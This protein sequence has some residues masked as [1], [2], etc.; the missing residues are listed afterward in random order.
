LW[1]GSI[2]NGFR[3]PALQQRFYSLITTQSRPSGEL[4]RTGTFRNDSEV[5]K[6]FGISP[7]RAEKTINFSTGVTS[8]IS[9]NISVTIDAYWIQIKNRIIY[10]GTILDTFP[11]VRNILNNSNFKD[12]QNARFFSNA[13][14]TRTIGIDIVFSGSWIIDRSTL[15]V[16]LAANINKTSLYGFIQYAKNLPDN[17][18]F[19]NLLVNREERCR[20][21]SAYPKDKIVLNIL[22][23][24]DKWKFHSSFMRYGKISQ[25]G[26]TPN[27]FPDE[28]FS[29]K[30]VT[31]MNLC[32]SLRSWLSLT[33]GAENMTDVYPDKLKHK[34]NTSNGITP[35]NGNFAA[36]GI[37]G[38]YYFINLSINLSSKK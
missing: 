10:S 37:N 2:S 7:L 25:K 27:L 8:A 15:E 5:A 6:A 16:S 4:F 3:A 24:K 19:R 28:E 14:N 33:V 18:I 34:S 30:I 32:Y 12:V 31:A 13:I 9:K 38:G 22:Y 1:R 11:E 20:V 29:P 36:F 26:N 35:Y 17:S 21:E 23:K